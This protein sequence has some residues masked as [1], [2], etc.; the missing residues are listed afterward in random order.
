MKVHFP[1]LRC[2]YTVATVKP[3]SIEQRTANSY[4]TLMLGGGKSIHGQLHGN[5][6][7]HKRDLHRITREFLLL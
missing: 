5:L 2:A 7:K 4:R 6:C 3:T 1:L